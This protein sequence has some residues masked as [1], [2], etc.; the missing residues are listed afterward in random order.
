MKR[1]P[2]SEELR[3]QVF[4]RDHYTCRYC[5]SKDGPLH[6]DHVYPASKGGET[7]LSNLVTACQH[8][9]VKKGSRVGIWPKPIRSRVHRKEQPSPVGVIMIV[10]GVNVCSM[11]FLS[12]H[13]NYDIPPHAFIFIGL[14]F[15]LFE[16]W[17][18]YNNL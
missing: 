3:Q 13:Y 16:A 11:Y 2:I 10:I 14:A 17:I 18:Q 8:C 4:R 7:T 1:E 12:D 5:G 6:A 15:V 9:N